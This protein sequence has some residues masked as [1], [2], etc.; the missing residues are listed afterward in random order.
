MLSQ[1]I[2]NIIHKYIKFNKPYIQELKEFTSNLKKD[3]DLTNNK[4]YFLF[5]GYYWKIKYGKMN[6]YN[7]KQG[8]VFRLTGC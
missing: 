6:C 1:D 7:N 8:Y 5:G 2:Y 3:I 4:K